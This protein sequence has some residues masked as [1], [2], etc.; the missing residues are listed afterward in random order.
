M[1]WASVSATSRTPLIF[2]EKGTKI[3]EGFY[4]EEVLK[5]LLPWSREH[6]KVFKDGSQVQEGT[7]I[8]DYVVRAILE[9]KAC[10]KRH[11]IVDA[12]KSSLKKAWE[13]VPQE[14][15]WAAVES[16]PKRLKIQLKRSKGLFKDLRFSL[17]TE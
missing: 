15:L 2:V 13:E 17:K 10:A 5:E 4:L 12:L 9:E 1:V 14:T 3:N 6:F 8:M 16:Y 7:E 11:G